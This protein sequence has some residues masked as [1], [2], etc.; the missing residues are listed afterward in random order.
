MVGERAIGFAAVT[1][2]VLLTGG[3]GTS[4][5]GTFV[6]APAATGDR[7]DG[8]DGLGAYTELAVD[9][10]PGRLGITALVLGVSAG[11]AAV[12]MARR[13]RRG[14]GIYGEWGWMIPVAVALG[15]LVLPALAFFG[16]AG[17][18]L[19]YLRAA[20]PLTTGIPA[21]VAACVLVVA[22]CLLLLPGAVLPPYL[23]L[24]VRWP[25]LIGPVV[26]GGVVVAV[27]AG[28]VV[29]AGDDSRSIDH[30]T[31]PAAEVSPVPAAVH[32][33]RYRLTVPE[34]NP[35]GY[36]DVVVAGAGF[37]TAT[38]DG[39]V[40][41]DGATG[42]QLWHYRRDRAADGIGVVPQSLRS[43]PDD[44][45]LARWEERGWLALDARTGAV[46]WHDSDFGRD[47]EL[48]DSGDAVHA[49]LPGPLVRIDR[50]SPGGPHAGLIYYDP[51][52]GARRW[53]ADAAKGDCPE[54]FTQFVATAT[55]VHR[56]TACGAAAELRVTT[57]DAADGREIAAHVLPAA[58]AVSF[59]VS[60]RGEPVLVDAGRVGYL[61][62]AAA[63]PV[64]IPEAYELSA[65]D[66]AGTL[67]TTSAG[68]ALIGAGSSSMSVLPGD[69]RVTDEWALLGAEAVR[70]AV[71][72]RPTTLTAASRTDPAAPVRELPFDAD[73]C[74][75]AEPI[76][77]PGALLIRCQG[78]L[79]GYG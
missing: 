51:R 39:L 35:A 10:V 77:V 79:I 61:L 72:R 73:H 11:I 56:V 22:G 59:D 1:G 6:A 8:R 32:A 17:A 60:Q 2:A 78:T 7:I 47:S 24:P 75:K 23:R 34:L 45:V 25:G 19:R 44:V 46:L 42:A 33:E 16:H 62:R 74:R 3:V 64:A 55:V 58:G 70:V 30:R 29:W 28:L 65:A 49:H 38:A 20:Q 40:A 68:T 67:V 9:A 5:Y 71:A 57:L 4:V 63:D 48:G 50:G 37:V 31:V 69:S 53:S 26:T 36:A 52:T 13:A 76:A 15:V 43:L 54:T 14:G 12:V 27:A 21:V 66:D 18:A 41:Y